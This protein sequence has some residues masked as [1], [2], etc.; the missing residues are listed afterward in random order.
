MSDG[1]AVEP[2]GKR[3]VVA[4]GHARDAPL[5][6]APQAQWQQ[7]GATWHKQ[8]QQLWKQFRAALD[9]LY[10]RRNQ[11]RQ[12]AIDERDG[13]LAKARAI[14][15]RI[16]ALAQQTDDLLLRSRD[17]FEREKQ[18]FIDIG[19]LP[20][21]E[22]RNIQRQFNEACDHFETRI[23]GIGELTNPVTQGI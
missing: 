12:V 1:E 16:G 23:D 22:F 3:L 4:S 9:A 2:P 11:E 14:C 18:A 6:L 5:P 7:V 20:K 8:N 19:A 17:E 15:E 10:E 21:Q 13:N